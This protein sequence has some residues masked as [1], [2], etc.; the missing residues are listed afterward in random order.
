MIYLALTHDWELRGDGSGD[1]E[2]IQFAPMQRL[3]EIYAKAGARVTILPELMQQISFRRL[4]AQHPELK[5]AA[6]SWDE[7]VREAAGQG[8]DIQLHIHPHWL[9]GRYEDGRW[10][11]G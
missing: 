5:V 6:D 4:A 2:Q 7:E 11:L 10:Q 3:L 9:N 8:H 1:I